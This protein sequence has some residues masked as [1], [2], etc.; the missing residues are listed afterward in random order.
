MC[1]TTGLVLQSVNGEQCSGQL[2]ADQ[3]DLIRASGRPLTIEFRHP[4]PNE[5][6]LKHGG[7]GA[8][9]KT[10]GET[11]KVQR[12]VPQQKAADADQFSVAAPTSSLLSPSSASRSSAFKQTGPS[13]REQS[14]QPVEEGV[15]PAHGQAT[16]S[17]H[18]AAAISVRQ[19]DEWLVCLRL[20]TN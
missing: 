2:Y 3:I 17:S 8:P 7:K 12:P 13:D 15:P 20:P 14:I 1:R 5:T 6:V 4:L 18:R 9:G 10:S 19:T 16:A 11:Q